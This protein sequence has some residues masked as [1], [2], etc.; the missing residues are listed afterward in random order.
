MRMSRLTRPPLPLAGSIRD[1]EKA[2]RKGVDWLV[3]IDPL[4]GA[5][6]PVVKDLKIVLRS[7]CADIRHL[8][9]AAIGSRSDPVLAAHRRNVELIDETPCR[10]WKSIVKLSL[11]HI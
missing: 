8:G 10:V 5:M 11:I 7:Q 1:V 4:G 9:T 3:W 6:M 2:F